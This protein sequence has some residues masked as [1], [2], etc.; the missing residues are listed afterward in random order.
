MNRRSSDQTG[1]GK[2]KRT[3][4]FSLATAIL[5]LIPLCLSAA[6]A[7]TSRAATAP[8]SQPVQP[9]V[10]PAPVVQAAPVQ[11]QRIQ[12]EA[13]FALMAAEAEKGNANAMLTLGRFYEQGVGV[14]R[15]YT[16][17]MEWYEKAAKAGQAEGY[18]NLGVC[19][20]IGMGVTADAGKAIQNY[21]KA[22]DMGLALAMYKLSS[23]YISGTGAPRDAAKGIS[24]LEKAANAGMAVAAN[25]LGG[26]YL[27]GLLGQKKDEKKALAMFTKAADLG[28]LEAV[29]NIAVMHKDGVGTK[30]DPAAAY[31]WYLIAR[32]GGY[33]GE[34]IARMLGLLEGSL[35]PAQAQQAQKD[36]D[37]W[38]ESY[39]NRQAGEK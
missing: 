28:N 2:P 15:N 18:Y 23:I 22:A 16:K 11:Q 34:D 32:R 9:A 5:L 19:Y 7:K 4:F 38:I 1:S 14:A 31:T 12:P 21:Q 8:A 37:A 20:E 29:K 25:D 39:A 10:Q 24:Y 3:L 33:A 6:P 30:A 13:A 35:T 36:A 17:A 26:I 27:S